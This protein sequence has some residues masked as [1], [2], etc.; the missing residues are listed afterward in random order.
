MF[1]KFRRRDEGVV[2]MREALGFVLALAGLAGVLGAQSPAD[3]ALRLEPAGTTGAL[4]VGSWTI[5]GVQGWSYGVCHDPEHASLG[6]CVGG[7]Y[8]VTEV[9]GGACPRLACPTDLRTIK[10]GAPPDFNTVNVYANGV[11]QGVVLDFLQA[12]TLPMTTRME[13]LRME[14]DLRAPWLNLEFCATL[15]TP[16]IDVVFVVGGQSF[17]PAVQE[18]LGRPYPDM[19]LRLAVLTEQGKEAVE[20]LLDTPPK[21][22]ANGFSF[23]LAHDAAGVKVADVVPGAAVA[24]AGGADYWRATVIEGRGATVGCVLDLEP[25]GGVFRVLPAFTLGQQIA[26]AHFAL[27]DGAGEAAT[28]VGF[29]GALGEP[30]VEILVDV[31]G[32][33]RSPFLGDAVAVSVSS[34]PPAADFIRG[35]ANQ[36][37][38]V[39]VAD[40]VAILRALFGGGTKLA[41]IE[42]CP[43]SA[44]VNDDGRLTVSDATY[45]LAY[46]FRA[47]PPIPA[48]FGACGPAPEGSA[49]GCERFRCP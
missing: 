28:T 44:D 49:L 9:C 43:A 38:K 40:A 4:V 7:S 21:E 8:P 2:A 41:M 1:V 39:N 14:Y 13:L 20:V 31:A 15:G 6:D 19:T 22:S 10:N 5:D 47:G 30:P 46:L 18:K 34:K 35:D 42:A 45:E 29:S 11:V 16:T 3:F 27:A 23:G 48:P 36:D 17:V 24:A 33:S 26:V 12:Q 37:G 32:E 25:E